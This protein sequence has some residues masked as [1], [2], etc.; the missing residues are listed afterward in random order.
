MTYFETLR[1]IE[2]LKLS[3]M[4][5]NIS[6]IGYFH[7]TKERGSHNLILKPEITNH[8]IQEQSVLN[9]LTPLNTLMQT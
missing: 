8:G 9:E 4:F 2:R 3:K 6:F 5:D 1:N 7:P